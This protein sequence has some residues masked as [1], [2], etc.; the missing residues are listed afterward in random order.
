MTPTVDTADRPNVPPGQG[1]GNKE[2]TVTLSKTE[3]EA[4][5]RDRDEARESERYWAG[6]AKTGGG[7]PSPEPASDPED[8]ISLDENEFVDPDAPDGLLAGDTPE[9]LVEDIAAHGV[10]AL[11]RRGYISRAEAERIAVDKATQVASKI[12]REVVGNERQKLVTDN[13]LLGKFPDL[14]NPQSE[15]FQETAKI[16]REAVEMDPSAKKTPAALYLAAKSAQQIIDSRGGGREDEQDRLDRVNAQ[17]GRTR[18]RQAASHDD[19]IGPE[20]ADI[21]KQMGISED[22]YKAEKAK[23]SGQGRAVRRSK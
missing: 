23:L 4:L 18:G 1:G 7:A 17:D 9:K 14:R 3:V 16:Y 21:I 20:A 2:E 19:L 10:E 13:R 5:R 12:A 8:E 6:I 15:L 11:R 22:D